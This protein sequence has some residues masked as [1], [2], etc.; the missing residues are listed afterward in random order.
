MTETEADQFIKRFVCLCKEFSRDTKS[1]INISTE[2][3]Y[4]TFHP[5]KIKKG[6]FSL[7]IDK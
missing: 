7:K 3:S 1:E 5:I 4:K 2:E 6:S